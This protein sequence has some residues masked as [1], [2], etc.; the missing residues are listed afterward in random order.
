MPFLFF[1]FIITGT[2]STCISVHHKRMWC[3]LRS[4]EGVL[5][6]EFQMF[7]SCYVGDGNH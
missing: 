2:L 6:L 4:K 3:L 1:C 5:E 7:M